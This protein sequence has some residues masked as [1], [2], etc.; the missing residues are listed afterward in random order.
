MESGLSKCGYDNC[1][2]SKKGDIVISQDYGLA[3]L[4]LGKKSLCYKS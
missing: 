4:V 2:W 1:K 3:A